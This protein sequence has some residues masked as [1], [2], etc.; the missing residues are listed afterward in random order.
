[1][2]TT[3][4]RKRIRE[5]AGQATRD[6]FWSGTGHQTRRIL[7]LAGQHHRLRAMFRRLAVGRLVHRQ[8]RRADQPVDPHGSGYRGSGGAVQPFLEPPAALAEVAARRL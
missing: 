2:S 3:E 6:K 8:L 5:P 4:R 7:L 1:M